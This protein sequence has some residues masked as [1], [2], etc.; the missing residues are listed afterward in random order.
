MNGWYK[1]VE[2]NKIISNQIKPIYLQI[3][4]YNEKDLDTQA[5]ENFKKYE[6]IGCRDISTLNILRK[7]GIDSYFSSCLTLTLDIDY[8]VNDYKRTN[9]II[10]VDYSF[11]KDHKIDKAILSL[12]S[13]NF[14]KITFLTHG[15]RNNISQIERFK[16][17]KN[18]LDKYARAKLVITN[19]LHV[20]FPCLALK[21]PVILVKYN[22]F[23]D[24]RFSG[25]FDFVNT[26]GNNQFG[27]FE[28]NVKLDKKNKVI[29]P[30]K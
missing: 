21:T 3:H 8:A 25:L 1:I 7:K 19:R 13:Y 17:A 6:P 30:N 5:I 20:A 29:N 28:V 15:L 23:D 11:G 22:F 9:E 18:Y 24:K 4:I 12:K 10:F 14:S 27:D 26:I 16:L 2:G